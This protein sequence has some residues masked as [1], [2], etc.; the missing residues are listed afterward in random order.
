MSDHKMMTH[1]LKEHIS[2][3][4]KENV[5][6]FN[7]NVLSELAVIYATKMDPTYKELFFK[8]MKE[9]FFRDLKFL[10]NDNFYKLI[11]S[12]VKSE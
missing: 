5:N 2:D 7:Y 1:D 3:Y 10:D 6:N 8:N 9:K 12:L 4:L 11:W